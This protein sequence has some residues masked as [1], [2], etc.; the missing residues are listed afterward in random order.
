VVEMQLAWPVRM[1]GGGA[2]GAGGGGGDDDENIAGAG[3]MGGG[4]GAGGGISSESA[5]DSRFERAILL[6]QSACRRKG[7]RCELLSLW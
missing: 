3:A 4:A 5:T 7:W 2:G 6:V 1:Q